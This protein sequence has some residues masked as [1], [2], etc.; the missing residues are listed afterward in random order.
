MY[1]CDSWVSKL[2]GDFFLAFISLCTA[3]F[4]VMVQKI[5]S[6]TFGNFP[7]IFISIV[8]RSEK[9]LG[10]LPFSAL[11][12]V[13]PR[14]SKSMFSQVKLR[15]SPSLKPVSFY[16]RTIVPIFF[17]APAT[18]WSISSSVGRKPSVVSW[19]L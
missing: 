19:C 17:P 5:F 13:I 2:N 3:L 7:I 1:L 18:S 6:L 15:H 9:Y 4:V 10:K 16:S 8:E 11:A 12:N 14:L